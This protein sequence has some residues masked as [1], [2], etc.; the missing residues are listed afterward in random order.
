MRQFGCFDELGSGVINIHK[1]LPLYANGAKPL[2]EDRNEGFCLTLPLKPIPMIPVEALVEAPVEALVEA[3]VEALV[4][5]PV[6]ISETERKILTCLKEGP[7]GRKGILSQLGYAQPSGN[8][9]ASMDRLL[10]GTLIERTIPDNPTSRLQQYRL[11]DK[12][13]R[14]LETLAT[15]R[16]QP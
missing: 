2:F 3:P 9:K 14:L 12:G 8:Y 10:N 6:R 4:E 1:Y 16:K 15:E 13:R 7:S 11:T 5:A